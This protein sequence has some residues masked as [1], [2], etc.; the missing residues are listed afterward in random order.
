[1]SVGEKE[2][3]DLERKYGIFCRKI[4]KLITINDL[5]SIDRSIGLLISKI[6]K[7]IEATKNEK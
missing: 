1:M 3:K 5:E 7:V 6:D 2:F 4:L